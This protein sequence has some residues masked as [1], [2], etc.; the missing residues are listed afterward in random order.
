[1]KVKESLNE[2]NPG[3]QGIDESTRFQISRPMLIPFRRIKTFEK[4][5]DIFVMAQKRKNKL[6]PRMFEINVVNIKKV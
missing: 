4:A 6:F 3:G 1:M 2:D 5:C